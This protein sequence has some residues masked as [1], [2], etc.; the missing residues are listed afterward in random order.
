MERRRGLT[1]ERVV[2]I[3]GLGLI[4]VIPVQA[5][6]GVIEINQ[7]KALAGGVT[8]SDFPGFPV[9]LDA[10]G[11]YRLTSNLVVP[12]ENTTAI[13]MAGLGDEMTIDLNGFGLIGPTR[14]SGSPLTCTPAGSGVGIFANQ[15]IT[16]R[17]GFIIGMG[18]RGI[19]VHSGAGAIVENIHVEHNGG[20]GIDVDGV[21]V[22]KNNRARFNGG[23]G[24]RAGLSSHVSDNTVIQSAAEGISVQAVSTVARNSVYISGGAG[25]D[26]VTGTIVQ[27]SVS[28]SGGDGIVCLATCTVLGNK[29]QSSGGFGLAL[30][31][32]SGYANN[33]LFANSGGTVS[34]GIQLGTN[35]CGSNTTCP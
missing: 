6:D 12:D 11:S 21:G 8:P 10:R 13:A 2:V 23:I 7:A 30:G 4:L 1:L 20:G 25:I 19:W 15:S 27:N 22:I 14:C 35:M 32:H 26:A 24:I 34:G 18:G 9:N 5:V 33:V 28:T 3:L 31:T 17:N 16:I 29:V